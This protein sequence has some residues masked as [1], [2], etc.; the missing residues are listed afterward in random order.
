MNGNVKQGPLTIIAKPVEFV[1]GAIAIGVL[2][3]VKGVLVIGEAISREVK[4]HRA[5]GGGA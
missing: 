1:A 4:R 2:Y 3:A 5:K